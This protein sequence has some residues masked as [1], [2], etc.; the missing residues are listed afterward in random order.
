MLSTL[1]RSRRCVYL[2]AFHNQ[3]LRSRLPL[4]RHR[5]FPSP[6]AIHYSPSTVTYNTP[7][8]IRPTAEYASNSPNLTF[9]R[10][11]GRP[12]SRADFEDAPG[13]STSE[14]KR[15]LAG[16]LRELWRRYE[17]LHLAAR[18][19]GPAVFG[20]ALS[21]YHLDPPP[22]PENRQTKGNHKARLS[23]ASQCASDDPLCRCLFC[24]MSIAVSSLHQLR[25]PPSFGALVGTP[26]TLRVG[27]SG[28]S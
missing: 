22:V 16:S 25:K 18:R 4:K 24:D 26:C 12:C 20:E 10:A 6:H 1:H 28:R 15:S 19:E 9:D 27:S 23:P 14:T 2:N 11:S 13:P 7:R 3:G 5:G 21:L 8:G 17:P